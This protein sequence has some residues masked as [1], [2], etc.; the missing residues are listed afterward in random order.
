MKKTLSIAC[1]LIA[2][3]IQSFSQTVDTTD[4]LQKSKNQKTAAW[5]L[6]GVG[7]AL[8]I[9]GIIT[10]VSNANKEVENL[11][12]ESSVNHGGEIALYIAGTAALAGS[13]VLFIRSKSNKNKAL[14]LGL[15]TKQFQQLKNG[16]LYTG[17]YPALTLKIGF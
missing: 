5:V 16:N 1:A 4:Y 13:L 14:S 9:A 6:L 8:D 3:V 7:A 2:I 15:D 10:T 17:S 11:F 12:E